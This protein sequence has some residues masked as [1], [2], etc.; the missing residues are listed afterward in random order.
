MLPIVRTSLLL[1]T[2]IPECSMSEIC[3]D[4]HESMSHCV[5]QANNIDWLID[6][7]ANDKIHSVKSNNHMDLTCLS[8]TSGNHDDDDDDWNWLEGKGLANFNRS[9]DLKSSIRI[10]S[11]AYNRVELWHYCTC[12][13]AHYHKFPDINDTRTGKHYETLLSACSDTKCTSELR[14]WVLVCVCVCKHLQ[15]LMCSSQVC[16]NS[17]RDKISFYI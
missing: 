9:I 12:M 3:L 14:E 10:N 2:Q 8:I 11:S 1:A 7:F 17:K 4:I 5:K 15:A 13:C 6:R 16:V